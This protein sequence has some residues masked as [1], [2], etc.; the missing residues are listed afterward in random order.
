[1]LRKLS[2]LSLGVFLFLSTSAIAKLKIGVVNMQ[3]A[4][5]STND[6]KKAEARLNRM[7]KKLETDL[8][9]KMQKFQNEEKELRKSWAI[10]KDGDKRKRA[11]ASAQKFQQLRQEYLQAE[12]RLLK[13]KTQELAKISKK[14]NRVIQ[15]VAKKGKYDY[16]FANAAVL[17]APQH[18][19]LTNEIIRIYNNGK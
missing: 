3:R 6:G 16:I 18:V 15:K 4:V 13:K 10:L 7:K 9:S 12:R 2:L 19:D 8:N 11:Q 17:W 5:A 1:M 14:L